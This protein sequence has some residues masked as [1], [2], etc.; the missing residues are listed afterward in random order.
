MVGV[1]GK[2]LTVTLIGEAFAVAEVTH[3]LL[4]VKT[5]LKISPLTGMNA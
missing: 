2:G 5:R 3:V 1:L 4:D